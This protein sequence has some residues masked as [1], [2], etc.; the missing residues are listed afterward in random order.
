MESS[1]ARRAGARWW[2]TAFV[3]PALALA[4]LATLVSRSELDHALRELCY[5]PSS[6]SFPLVDSWFFEGVLVFGGGACL[7]LAV[8]ALAFRASRGSSDSRERNAYVL[9]CV[10]LTTALAFA[11]QSFAPPVPAR[12][13]S[14]LSGGHVLPSAPAGP[15]ALPAAGFAWIALFFAAPVLR[16]LP[17][18]AWLVPGLLLGALLACTQVVRGEVLASQELWSLALAWLVAALLA[19]AFE[20]RA[21]ARGRTA[22]VRTRRCDA[23]GGALE[24]GREH[25]D[26]A[27]PWL[28]GISAGLAGVAFFFG[29]LLLDSFDDR[30]VQV[31]ELFEHFELGVMGL[32]IGIGAYFLAEHVRDTRV[33]AG[34]RLA[35]QREERFRVLGRMAAAV[36]HEVRNPLHTLRLILDEQSHELP[37]LAKHPLRPAVDASLARINAAVDL[38]YRLARPQGEEGS[39]ADLVRAARDAIASVERSNTTQVRFAWTATEETAIVRGSHVALGIVIDNLIRNA[40]AASPE[41]SVVALKL[42]RRDRDWT[43]EIL[44]PGSLGATAEA[45]ARAR[46][47][48]VEGLGLGLSI[49]RQIAA[50]AGGRIELVDV[51]GCV[52]C[53]LSWP[54]HDGMDA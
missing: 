25:A 39:Q 4:L 33:R 8:L 27:L 13:A 30:Y 41:G 34:R 37:A 12:S 54:A 20:R 23:G 15:S 17:R 44:N 11:W 26:S 14:A 36:A 10:L 46:G 35:L 47:A 18:A 31:K 22:A 21:R 5:A 2:S 38:V 1:P 6:E 40:A 53:T 49:S 7:A 16:T 24:L 9:S 29:D 50:S 45:S 28:A 19:A 3:L 48:S 43:L 52:R 42:A 51:D 32:G